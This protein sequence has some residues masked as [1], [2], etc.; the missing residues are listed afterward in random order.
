MLD[1]VKPKQFKDIV[2]TK[3]TLTVMDGP[4]VE[5]TVEEVIKM[6]VKDDGD[7]PADV[8]KDPFT[9]ILSG[10][11]HHQAPDGNYAVGFEKIGVLEGLFVD[12]KADIPE[13]EKF[14]E[15]KA[16]EATA[17]PAEDDDSGEAAEGDEAA[18]TAA[19]PAEPEQ[20]VLYE[21]VFG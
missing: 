16:K 20:S 4:D 10:P 19:A 6:S 11:S 18:P 17:A 7:R 21:I 1:K 9:V 5:L 12:N 13:C 15:A 14:N 8:R 2:G 3:A